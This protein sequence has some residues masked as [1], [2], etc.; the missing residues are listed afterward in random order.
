[1]V[2]S[3][4]FARAP[5]DLRPVFNDVDARFGGAGLEMTEKSLFRRLDFLVNEVGKAFC[6]G[7]EEP[8][9]AGLELIKAV[10]HQLRIVILE[11]LI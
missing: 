7:L 11:G 6:G 5:E 4:G 3:T 9:A 2:R 8:A 10:F 1:M